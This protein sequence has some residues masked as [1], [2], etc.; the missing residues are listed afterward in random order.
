M[1]L[2]LKGMH[3]KIIFL[4]ILT[5]AIPNLDIA[6]TRLKALFKFLKTLKMFVTLVYCFNE[7]RHFDEEYVK[8][9]NKI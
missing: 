8:L 6:A 2:K 1:L 9:Q 3:L 5:Q 7:I 4:V